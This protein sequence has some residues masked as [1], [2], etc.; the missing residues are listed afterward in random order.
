MSD[1]LKSLEKHASETLKPAVEGQ[2][3]AT[4]R[5]ALFKR[6]LNIEEERILM[7]HRSGAGGLEIARNRASLIDTI[8]NPVAP[9]AQPAATP[10]AALRQYAAPACRSSR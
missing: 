4:E 2:L 1:Y 6:F 7:R 10:N 3:T 9:P 5:I 8:A